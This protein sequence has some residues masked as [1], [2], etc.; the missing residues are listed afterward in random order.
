MKS[1]GSDLNLPMAN[2]VFTIVTGRGTHS[3][4]NRKGAMAVVTHAVLRVFWGKVT[5]P[6]AGSQELNIFELSAP[7]LRLL[8]KLSSE[9][10]RHD[11]STVLKF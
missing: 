11:V 3:V 4:T 9:A 10:Y 1:L 7:G 8:G 6:Y 2:P 5:S